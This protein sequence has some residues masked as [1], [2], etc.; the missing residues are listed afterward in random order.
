[1]IPDSRPT[2]WVGKGGFSVVVFGREKARFRWYSMLSLQRRLGLALGGKSS[3]DL[4]SGAL[5]LGAARQH[6]AA[7]LAHVVLLLHGGVLQVLVEGQRKGNAE[8]E[9]RGGYDPCALAAKGHDAPGTVGDGARAV[10]DPAA[11][12]GGYD[13]AE[14]VEALGEGLVGGIKIGVVGDFRLWRVALAKS[15]SKLVEQ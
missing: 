9:N 10:G 13:V 3:A 15:P 6:I 2:V 8:E 1:M 5:V 14:G 12:L 7:A 4:V 11:G